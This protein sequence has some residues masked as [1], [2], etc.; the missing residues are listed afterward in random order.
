MADACHK[1]LDYIATHPNAGIHHLTSNMI[2]AVHTDASY[3]SIHN[4]CSWASAHF[5]LTNKG[6]KEFNNGT[7]PNL[8]SIIKYVMSLASEVKLVACYYTCKL[9]VPIR[10]TLDKMGHTQPPT[11]VGTDNI[12]A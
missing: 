9:A 8:T 11:P 6:N 4:A 5:Y 7:I 1:H 3:L 10:M 12:T 2:F